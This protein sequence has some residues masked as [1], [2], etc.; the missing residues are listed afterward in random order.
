MW[1]PFGASDP[2][3]SPPGDRPN[4]TVR[5]LEGRSWQALKM[6]GVAHVRYRKVAN[7]LSR[8]GDMGFEAPLVS[9]REG[10]SSLLER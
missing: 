10:R 7:P 2:S 5:A 8:Y 9:S 1:L 4:Q 3:T 6:V